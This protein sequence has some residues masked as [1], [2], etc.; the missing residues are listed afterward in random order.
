MSTPG[1]A[2]VPSGCPALGDWVCRGL[3]RVKVA[4]LF[5]LNF[6]NFVK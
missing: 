2:F 5:L 3:R 1:F 4:F 6:M